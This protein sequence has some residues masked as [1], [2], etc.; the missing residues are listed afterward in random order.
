MATILVIFWESI[1]SNDQMSCILHIKTFKSKSWPIFLWL[2]K[3]QP[4]PPDKNFQSPVWGH[5][6]PVGAGQRNSEIKDHFVD[7]TEWFAS[8]FIDKAIVSF[9]N[10]FQSCVVATGGHWHCEHCLNTEWAIRIWH[11][12]LKHLNCWWKAV[13]IWL[14]IHAYSVCSATACSPEKVNFKV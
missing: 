12:W 8:R 11:S 3:T 4:N 5:L 7:D 2:T 1:Q 14:V 6:Q 9:C 13:K 10:R